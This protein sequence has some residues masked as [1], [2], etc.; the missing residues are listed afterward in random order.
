VI[1]R[2]RW[3]S[4]AADPA[5]QPARREDHLRAGS[6]AQRLR[7]RFSF[8]S[9]PLARFSLSVSYALQLAATVSMIAFHATFRIG[10]GPEYLNAAVLHIGMGMYRV[11][12][13]AGEAVTS[14]AS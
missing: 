10:S 11:R 4:R 2:S 1:R 12:V 5:D 14:R 8:P 9:H 13:V 6:G 7:A 3:G